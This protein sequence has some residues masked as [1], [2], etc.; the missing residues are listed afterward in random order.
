MNREFQIKEIID[1]LSILKS[2]I[3]F[4][5]ESNLQDINI[6]YEYHFQEI[7]NII[8]EYNLVNTNS[9]I[10]NSKAID[11]EDLANGVAVQITSNSRKTKIQETLNKFFENRFDEKY[12][13]LLILILGK[14]QKTYSNLI[15]KE[16]FNFNSEDNIFDFSMLISKIRILP[17]IKIEKINKILKNDK[18]KAPKQNKRAVFKNNKAIRKK[19]V[20]ALIRNLDSIDDITISHY[21]LSYRFLYE[22]LIIRSIDDKIFPYFDDPK[23]GKRA[24]WYKVF[25]YNL[26]EYYLEVETWYSADII[27][28]PKNGEWNYLEKRAKED[29]SKDFI[30]LDNCRILERISLDKIVDIDMSSEDPIIFVEFNDGKAHYEELPYIRG[31][32]RN[33]NDY[34]TTEYFELYKQNIEL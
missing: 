8:F 30:I 3:E 4:L 19:I 2:K 22:D 16:G 26:E 15:I 9:K 7:L 34:R 27:V 1:E 11:L 13:T 32:Y 20:S 5:N 23:T 28:N 17:N 24:D 10:S 33:I 14:K 21:D 31:Y 18:A 29:I 6:I 25:S 12:S